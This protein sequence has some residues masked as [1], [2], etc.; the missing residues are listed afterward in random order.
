MTGHNKTNSTNGISAKYREKRNRCDN[1]NYN[2][3]RYKTDLNK[4]VIHFMFHQLLHVQEIV[5]DE[6]DN[7]SSITTHKNNIYI[8]DYADSNN[9]NN[10]NNNNNNKWHIYWMSVGHV[11]NIFTGT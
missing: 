2:I 5:D 1:K 10:N 3:V 8:N 9:S 7:V 6:S 11:H 4:Q